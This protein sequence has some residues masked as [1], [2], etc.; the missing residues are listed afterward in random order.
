MKH[1]MNLINVAIEIIIHLYL[2]HLP[3]HFQIIILDTRIHQITSTEVHLRAYHRLLMHIRVMVLGMVVLPTLS[4]SLIIMCNHQITLTLTEVHLPACHHHLIM[5]IRVTAPG[6]VVLPTL[7][8]RLIII[9]IKDI[10]DTILVLET[11][12]GETTI[13]II[14]KVDHHHHSCL[15]I[16]LHVLLHLWVR[17]KTIVIV[18]VIATEIDI[19]EEMGGTI[20][21]DKTLLVVVGT[22]GDEIRYL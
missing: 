8:L 22:G 15:L 2:Q 11:I 9:I 17:V 10:M 18:I 5:H 20:T 16:F 12:V 13:I 14:I 7:N 4:P 19:T 21:E 6:M 1:L 3:K